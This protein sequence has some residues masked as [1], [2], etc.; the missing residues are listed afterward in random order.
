MNE[1]KACRDC[2]SRYIGCHSTCKRHLEEKEAHRQN[3]ERAKVDI[4]FGCYQSGRKTQTLK[5]YR[6]KHK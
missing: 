5:K 1:F 3:M 6:N 2:T 4:M